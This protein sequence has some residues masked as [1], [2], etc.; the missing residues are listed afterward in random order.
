M[1]MTQLT[2]AQRRALFDIL[3]H[4]Q[5]YAE[6]QSFRRPDAVTN[7]GYPFEAADRNDDEDERDS[8]S[9]LLQMLLTRFILPLPG[10]RSLPREFW[11]VRVQGLMARLAEAEL[12]E[13]YDRGAL[14][15]RKTLATGSSVLLEMIARGCLGGLERQTTTTTTTTTKTSN[16]SD[17]MDATYDGEQLAKAWDEVAQGL[18]YG[19]LVDEL[20]EHISVTDDIESYSPAVAAAIDYIIIHLA[21]FAHSVFIRS[22]EGQYLLKLMSQVHGLVPYKLIKQTLR[23]GNAATM[24][25]GIS[26]LLLAKLSVA[27]VT[28]WFGLTQ[29]ADDGMNLVQRIISL[30]LSW[31]A[32]E[33]R[34]SADRVEKARGEDRPPDEALLRLRRHLAAGRE[35]HEEARRKSRESSRS[36]V[37]E[38]LGA[39]A[40][41]ELTDAQHAQCLEFY[42]SLWSVRDRDSIAAALCR[43]PPDLFTQAVKDTMAAYDPMIRA[44]HT[45]VDLRQHVEATQGFIDDFIRASRPG[46]DGRSPVV[47][48]YVGLLRRNRGLLYK[49]VH[50][51]ARGCPDVREALRAWAKESIVR[52]RKDGDEFDA[53][54]DELVD[55]L[56]DDSVRKQVLDAI[57]K[58]ASYLDNLNSQSNKRLSSLASNP[59]WTTSAPGAYLSRWQALLDA[60][61]VTP[62]TR[63]GPIRHGR[64]V[65]HTVAMGKTTTVSSGPT[66]SSAGPDDAE[67]HVEG[68]DVAVVVDALAAGFAGLV[69]RLRTRRTRRRRLR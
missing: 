1:T 58:H 16:G 61:T 30:V 15:S 63:E 67:H 26:R 17:D 13:S 49:W 35:V 39:E 32:A 43:T 45:S 60:T 18:V 27:S 47:G 36:I 6:I 64:D 57:D 38:V 24:M 28:N 69:S 41:D 19:N 29:K 8:A 25:S 5:T 59:T 37:A 2:R 4:H 7:Y 42:S 14:G 23:V 51:L 62:S 54:L 10:V 34:K 44:V 56:D 9:P 20:F 12:S 33:F 22:A 40:A 52:F 66:V 65:K 68:P 46:D 21:G 11:R 3:T 53:G 50:A 31:D 55:G 48:D